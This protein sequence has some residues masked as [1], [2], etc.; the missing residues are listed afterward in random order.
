MS[1]DKT[2]KSPLY[3]RA[4]DR[5]QT[6]LFGGRR[7]PKDNL[8]VEAYGCVDELNSAIGV[9]AAFTRQR[10]LIRI[11]EAIQNELFNIGAELASAQSVPKLRRG[12][13]TFSLSQGKIAELERWIDEYDAKLPPLKTF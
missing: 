7:V 9:A 3:T 1:R 11:L 6:S 10:R 5:G 13:E 8:R 12:D 2:P 4:G